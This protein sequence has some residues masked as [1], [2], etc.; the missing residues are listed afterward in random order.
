[1]LP[2]C[3]PHVHTPYCDG[4]S[5]IDE[6]VQAALDAG[7]VSLGFSSHAVQDIDPEYCIAREKE[8]DYIDEVNAAQKAYEDRI[9]IWRGIER[10]SVSDADRSRYE[11]VLG[12]VHYMPDG[13]FV[14]CV[15][16]NANQLQKE[17]DRRYGGQ[18]ARMAIEYYQVLGAYIRSYRPDI[19]AHFDLV[20]KNN[21]KHQLFDPQDPAVF[22]AARSAMEEAI[23]GCRVLEINTGAMVRSGAKEPYPS[24]P[25]LK[26]WHHLGGQ[27]ILASDC[28]FAP[29]IAACYEEGLALMRAAGYREMLIL[30]RNKE[31]FETVPL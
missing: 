27:V 30:G 4:Q 9:R 10:D 23:Q 24:L 22:D 13:E 29:H 31:L 3:S 19:I 7:F 17:I 18:G 2:L 28:H 8:Q 16:G 5:T 11:Y 20:M 6:T 1:M 26:H 12:A 21:R 25:L 15:D 14:M